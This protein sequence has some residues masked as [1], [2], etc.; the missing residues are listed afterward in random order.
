M[1]LFFNGFLPFLWIVV[2]IAQ[3]DFSMLFFGC[4]IIVEGVF[5]FGKFL[6]LYVFIYLL[7]SES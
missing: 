7:N 4:N 5:L 2:D 6:R 1:I 3:F